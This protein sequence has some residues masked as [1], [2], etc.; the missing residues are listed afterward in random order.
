MLY[1]CAIFW[2]PSLLDKQA[3]YRN[4][5]ES[6]CGPGIDEIIYEHI[7]RPT[8]VVSQVGIGNTSQQGTRQYHKGKDP[9]ANFF[10]TNTHV[11]DWRK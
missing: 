6:D 4:V 10:R 1:L 7:A 8:S 2:F 5:T 3:L 11:R 9:H